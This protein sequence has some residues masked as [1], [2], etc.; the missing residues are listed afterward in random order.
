M[1]MIVE[2][3]AAGFVGRR[4]FTKQKARRKAGLRCLERTFGERRFV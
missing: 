4:S 2:D 1:G 3:A